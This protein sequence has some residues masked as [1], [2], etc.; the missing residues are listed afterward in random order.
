MSKANG[1]LS[2]KKAAA[3]RYD[4]EKDG[5]PVITA[6]GAGH[7]A[8]KIVEKARASDVPVVEDQKVAD[9]LTRFSVGD[10]IPA[11]LYEAVAQILIFVAETD[12]AYKDRIQKS[13]LR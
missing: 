12:G 6:V 3:L 8:K 2:A 10:A 11:E 13:N 9:V 4:P 7:V 1:N 5:T